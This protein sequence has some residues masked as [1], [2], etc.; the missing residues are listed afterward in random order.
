MS[1]L[2]E[3]FNLKDRCCSRLI[4][5]IF[6]VNALSVFMSFALGFLLQKY[7]RHIWQSQDHQIQAILAQ[8]DHSSP[9][10]G[11]PVHE[12]AQPR[13]AKSDSADS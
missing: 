13:A 9:A 12:C 10:R 11:A 5:L 8:P 2:S 3:F 6:P 7:E 4:S 1:S